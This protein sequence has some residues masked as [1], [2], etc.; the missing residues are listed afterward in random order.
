MLLAIFLPGAST[1]WADTLTWQGTPSSFI[2]NLD[3]SSLNWS[4]SLGALGPY[5]DGNDVVFDDT[6]PT[7]AVSIAVLVQPNSITV[8]TA[9]TNYAFLNGGG[10]IG[11]ATGL[12]KNG[13]G[14]F[15]I[16]GANSFTGN[17]VINSGVVLVGRTNALGLNNGNVTVNPGGTLDLRGFRVGL[18]MKELDVAGNGA[19]WTN[20]LQGAICSG[21]GSGSIL[22]SG[23]GM[24]NIVLLG[25]TT[26]RADARWDINGAPRGGI[27]FSG[28][29]YH[30]TKLGANVIWFQNITNLGLGDID[31]KEGALGFQAYPIDMGDPTKTITLWPGTVFDFWTATNGLVKNM[32][33]TNA[34][35]QAGSGSNNFFG[36]ITLYGTNQFDV[37]SG[38]FLALQ[39]AISGPGGFKKTTA[40]LLYLYGTN[41]YTGPTFVNASGGR[42]IVGANSSLGNSS[43]I[44]LAAGTALDVSAGSG[45]TLG[46]GQTLIGLGKHSVVGN[47]TNRA[48]S[49]VN[50]GN[51]APGLLG[52]DF[53]SQTD[54][55]NL[56]V[57]GSNPGSVDGTVNSFIHVTNDLALSGVVTF[58]FAPVGLL[59][60]STP[61]IVLQYDGALASGG[62]ANLRAVSSNPNYTFTFLDPATTA[63]YLEVQVSG[64]PI[65][66][67]WKGGVSPAPNTW[68]QTTANWLDA[69]T[70]QNTTFFNG[71][72]VTFD[73]TAATNMVSL[74][75]TISAS[76]LCNNVNVSYTFTGSGTLAGSVE[77]ET[78]GLV[79]LALSNAPTF[80]SIINNQG[81]L[82]FNLQSTNA[83]AVAATISDD[84][85]GLGTIVQAG[86]NTLQLTGNNLGYSG[87]FVVTNGVLQY[88][89]YAALGQAFAPLY[90]TNGGSLDFNDIDASLKNIVVS[91][92]GFN[93]AGAL[94]DS[95]AN[96]SPHQ[97]ISSMTLAGDTTIAAAGRWDLHAGGTVSGNGFNLTKI[98]GG[99]IWLPAAGDTGFK[100]INILA[101]VLGIQNQ[102]TLG[103]PAGTI[104]VGPGTIFGLW[105]EIPQLNKNLVLSN[106]GTFDSA[107]GS[108]SFAGTLT[109][110]GTNTIVMRTDFGL[111]CNIGGPGGFAAVTNDSLGAAAGHSLWLNGANTYSGPTFVR[112]G[113]TVVVASGSSLGN[114][115]LVQIDGGGTLNLSAP[116]V[117]GLGDGQTVTG[118][119]KILGGGMTFGPGSTLAVTPTGGTLNMTGDLTLQAGSTNKVTIN[120]AT[121]T[122]TAVVG[123]NSVTMGGTLVIANTGTAL[124]GGDQLSLFS[125]TNYAGTFTNI[126]PSTPGPGMAWD[127][128]SLASNGTLGV[129]VT[130]NAT[131]TN[132][133]TQVSGNQL[134]LSWPA[135]HIGWTLQ[136][137]TN[138]PGVGLGTNWVNVAGSS[139]TNLVVLPIAPNNGSVFFRMI[140]H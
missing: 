86:S 24:N 38:K 111:A 3:P 55:T 130:V 25:D 108:N 114:S 122:N 71:D 113:S 51:G 131:P 84:G 73:D 8:N 43:L 112:A 56:M 59:D 77:Q 50:V 42:I 68:D 136:A 100:D 16:S 104:T 6:A 45:L 35:L 117:L 33:M 133:V 115:S 39:G 99:Q 76:M 137:Q 67:V 93:G 69:S 23:G 32:V 7:N 10:S 31:V 27:G 128:S 87:T 110:F 29:G 80:S 65:P 125:A 124:A 101:G 129:I 102:A 52:V 88:G 2:W 40:G 78:A 64:N 96:A 60:T 48:G 103:D 97:V 92:T 82:A 21:P 138:A 49:I 89:N 126:V 53:L 36:P 79:T 19:T 13:T 66:L 107:G 15:T 20:G 94:M 90:V 4:N 132:I 5:A 44:Q 1:T 120:K 47:L 121:I 127:T 109:L 22:G 62:L 26:F 105:A 139:V 83:A 75:G 14:R 46:L 11:G 58:Q 74:V 37:T 116:V 57:L 123:L 91:G 85:N 9:T 98:G 118:H 70:S 81:I 106:G 140:I 134:T 18:G 54:S 34:E 119:G 72:I 28:N 135:D 30:L 63:P 12:T 95:S 17:T 61:Y 41:T